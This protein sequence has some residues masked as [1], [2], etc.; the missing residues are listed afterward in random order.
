MAY[1]RYKFFPHW[2]MVA[3]DINRIMV[4][5]HMVDHLPFAMIKTVIWQMVTPSSLLGTA[6]LEEKWFEEHELLR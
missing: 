6:I 3:R 1:G 4:I 2:H 5:C